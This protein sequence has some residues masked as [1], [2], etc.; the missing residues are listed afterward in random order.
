M[1][2]LFCLTR[3]H[4]EVAQFISELRH[5]LII[6]G[7][8]YNRDR[9][10][11]GSR[12]IA[13][14]HPIIDTYVDFATIEEIT[15][16]AALVLASEYDRIRTTVSAPDGLQAINIG[17]WRP[18][19]LSAPDDVGFLSLLGVEP[20]RK[21]MVNRGGVYIVPFLAGTGCVSCR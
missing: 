3:N 7:K 4:D 20:P 9:M 8:Q 11:G 19:V 1:P 17:K 15:P 10:R 2:A 13:R 14:R 18:N 21:D 6:A 16:A 12:W 5:Q